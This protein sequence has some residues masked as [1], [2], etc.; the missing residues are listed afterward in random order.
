MDNKNLEELLEQ[1]EKTIAE[2]DEKIAFLT[3][4]IR[5]YR[6]NPRLSNEGLEKSRQKYIDWVLEKAK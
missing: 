5:R 4:F 1:A 3:D 2:K 6:Y